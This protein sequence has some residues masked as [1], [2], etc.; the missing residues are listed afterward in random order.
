MLRADSPAA[1]Y[2][3]EE[4]N[5]C[6]SHRESL[7]PVFEAAPDSASDDNSDSDADDN[8]EEEEDDNGSSSRA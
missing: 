3:A 6:Y 8:S 5:K 2:T 1:R 4:L 7:R